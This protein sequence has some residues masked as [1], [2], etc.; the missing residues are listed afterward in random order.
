MPRTVQDIM[1]RELLAVRPDLSARAALDLLRSFRIGAAPVLDDAGRPIGVVAI[2][3]LLDAASVAARERMSRPALCVSISATV[4]QAARQLARMDL[5]HLVVV[6]GAGAAVGMLSTLDALRALL[7]VP[8][9]HPK[10]FPHWDDATEVSWTDPWPLE[11]E[12]VQYAPESAG[13]LV[14]ATDHLGERDAV[15]WAESTSHIQ[16]RVRRLATAPEDE[17]AELRDILALPG[18]RFRAAGVPEEASRARIVGLLRQRMDSTPP[19][20][21]T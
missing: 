3:D 1:N 11:L 18:L 10:T 19:P 15:H 13:V 7:D 8:A 14:L 5:H 6:D 12:A 4:E 2:R 20:G 21:G 17:G 9:R 16:E